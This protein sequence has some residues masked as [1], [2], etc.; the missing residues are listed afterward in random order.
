M[1]ES[2][3]PYVRG[4]GGELS[5]HRSRRATASSTWSAVG[6]LTLPTC[7]PSQGEVTSSV[8]SPVALRPASQNA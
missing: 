1:V 5:G 8:L 3:G 6:M 4:G 7:L 2:G